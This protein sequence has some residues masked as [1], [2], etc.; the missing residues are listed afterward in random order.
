MLRGPERLADPS[1]FSYYWHVDSGT[2]QREPPV[3]ISFS[4]RLSTR[5]R[6]G[7]EHRLADAFD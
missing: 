5:F 4:T 7:L 3:S 1:G 6:S 2:I